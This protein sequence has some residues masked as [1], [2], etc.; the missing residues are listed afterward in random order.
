MMT[1]TMVA[2]AGDYC[3]QLFYPFISFFLRTLKSVKLWYL[4]TSWLYEHDW[5]CITKTPKFLVKYLLLWVFCT[6]AMHCCALLLPTV[7]YG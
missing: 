6:S 2:S 4:S 5:L 7:S 1:E 3:Y